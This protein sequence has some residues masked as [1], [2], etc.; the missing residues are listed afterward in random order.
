MNTKFSLSFHNVDFDITDIHGQPWLRSFQIGSALGYKN[1]SSDMAKLY[2]RNA[3]E[4]TDSMTQVI[5]LPTTG[6]KQQVRVFSLRGAHLLGMLARTK[7]AKEFRRWVLDVL[8]R[9]SKR[10]ALPATREDLWAQVREEGFK[11]KYIPRNEAHEEMLNLLHRIE[12]VLCKSHCGPDLEGQIRALTGK[13]RSEL[14][15]FQ[16]AAL[17]R[18]LIDGMPA[19]IMEK[20][21]EI[22]R[23]KA[24]HRYSFDRPAENL[25]ALPDAAEKKPRPAPANAAPAA[26]MYD[27]KRDRRQRDELA[28]RYES[29]I[30][31]LLLYYGEATDR[32]NEWAQRIKCDALMQTAHLTRVLNEVW[33]N[34]IHDE[35]NQSLSDYDF[36]QAILELNRL[37]CTIS[38]AANGW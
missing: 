34:F 29:D 18:R 15:F 14:D 16:L 11:K 26:P 7:A 25:P 6:G 3:D 1:P 31:R 8:E 12:T 32:K 35:E 38:D 20:H 36:K 37:H 9:E 21:P 23:L 27:E 5:E 24:E 22:R 10:P 33:N 2:D 28:Q 13:G 4:F 30:A 17:N 19:L